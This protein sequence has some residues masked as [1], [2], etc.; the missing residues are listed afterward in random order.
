MKTN[1]WQKVKQEEEE[2]NKMQ[3]GVAAGSVVGSARI[4]DA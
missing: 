1:K 2:E 4:L 3:T